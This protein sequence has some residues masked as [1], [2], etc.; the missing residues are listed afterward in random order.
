MLKKL[1]KYGNSNAL[2]LD[3]AI[4]ELLN[5]PEGAHVK[6]KTDGTS[7]IISLAHVHALEGQE[8]LL[9]LE[10]DELVP[11]NEILSES[12]IELH[13]IPH[14]LRKERAKVTKKSTQSAD[15]FFPA[16]RIQDTLL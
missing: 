9:L 8:K 15:R 11:R 5:I 2:V 4:L 6:I 1:V 16:H 3:K 12:A 10:Q 14:L 13:G 7:L